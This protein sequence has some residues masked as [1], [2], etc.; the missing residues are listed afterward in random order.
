M[1]QLLLFA[2][3]DGRTMLH[4]GGFS[5][6]AMLALP[7]WALQRGLRTLAALALVWLM[8]PGPLLLLLGV[9]ESVALLCAWLL[10]VGYG[11]IAAPLHAAWM[12]RSGWIVLAEEPRRDAQA[13]RP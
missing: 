6:L 2:H 9:P 7:V 1:R 11:F 5:W 8:L 12:R 10:M 4:Q 13:V 3:P